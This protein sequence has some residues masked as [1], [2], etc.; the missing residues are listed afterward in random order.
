[1]LIRASGLTL[2][3]LSLTATLFAQEEPPP[4]DDQGAPEPPTETETTG[5]NETTAEEDEPRVIVINVGARELESF[6][7][8]NPGR[9]TITSSSVDILAAGSGDPNRLFE[10]L[11]NVQFATDQERASTS[12]GALDD[13]SPEQ[14]SISGGRPYENNFSIDGVATNSIADSVSRNPDNFNETL[15]HPQT[16]YLDTELLEQVTLYDSDV[17]AEYTGFT[18]GVISFQVRDP[19]DE[20][21]F[22]MGYSL[23]SS[24]WTEYLVDSALEPFLGVAPNIPGKPE[25]KQERYKFS[26]DLPFSD[27][28]RTTFSYTYNLATTFQP[29]DNLIDGTAREESESI[30][31]NFLF[32]VAYDL[33]DSV[34]ITAQSLFTPYEQEFLRRSI[35]TNTGGGNTSYIEWDQLF[36]DS[37][38]TVRV[39]YNSS[40]SNRD[41][42]QVRINYA[43]IGTIAEETGI[44]E[45][46]GRN[47]AFGGFG[48]LD[49][50]QETWGL[51]V[52]YSHFFDWF[53]FRAGID[54]QYITATGDRPEL[55]QFFDA[56]APLGPGIATVINAEEGDPTIIPGEQILTDRVDYVLYDATVNLNVFGIWTEFRREWEIIDW[57]PITTRWGLRYD[58]DEFLDRHNFSPR[59]TNVFSFPWDISLTLG[60]NRYYSNNQVTYKLREA[61]PDIFEYV[62]TSEFVIPPGGGLPITTYDATWQLS[63]INRI[64]RFGQADVNTP[65]SD[66]ISATITFPLLWGEARIKGVR[67]WNRDE[68]VRGEEFDVTLTD[69]TGTEF[70]TEL[71]PVTNDG[72]SNYESLVLAWQIQ[73]WNLTFDINTTIA[74]ITTDGTANFLSTPS[75]NQFIVQDVYYIPDGRVVSL[76][77]L[78]VIRSEFAFPN[79]VNANLTASLLNGNL[80]PNLNIR[81]EGEQEL[82]GQLFYFDP[83][84]PG[85]PTFRPDRTNDGANVEVPGAGNLE[86]YDSIIRESQVRLNL[87]IRA[88]L[89][90]LAGGKGGDFVVYG[91]I[92]NLLNDLADFRRSVTDPYQR[93]RSYWLEVKYIY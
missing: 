26:I 73:R 47:V 66:E 92:R 52:S 54:Y 27:Q 78:E 4:V 35:D 6:D 86:I 80:V 51:T 59:I 82:I 58:Y 45:D 91:R 55:A 14:I 8:V 24:N 90:F 93:G 88:K 44:P 79:V 50:E 87:N 85:G 10:T 81:Y 49:R 53:D 57:L 12:N 89:P 31:Q 34:Q 13:I 38:F 42:E 46:F 19:A 33:N 39:S 20:F 32:K 68:F 62:R 18:G 74:D 61:Y 1:M 75:E 76:E 65:Y 16:V 21:G 17:P 69:P 9:N 28:L 64:S 77:E 63:N 22:S 71:R 56:A 43:N 37:S 60:V 40:E 72:F 7:P 29:P 3:V 84:G 30:I 70:E 11:P 25:F 48:D 36:L 15:G 83:D 23:Q 67:R 2:L 5:S 41:S